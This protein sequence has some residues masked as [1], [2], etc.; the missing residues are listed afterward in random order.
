MEEM[1]GIK[2]A[3]K[4][5]L[6]SD[7]VYI[8]FVTA[9]ITYALEGYKVNAVRYLLKEEEN[10][11]NALKECLD[12]IVARM[13][14]KEVMCEFDF[15]NKKKLIPADSILYVESRLHKVIFFVME[16]V[17]TEYSKYDKLDAVEE[18]LKQYGF[19]RTHQSFLVNMKYAKGVERYKMSLITGTQISISK[20][21]YKSV[22]NEYIKQQGDI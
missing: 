1:D 9:Y 2:T 17:I 6:V 20:K 15:S 22:E 19:C 21:Y 8:V 16:D 7:K 3:E 13:N 11:T 10:L 5:R 12:T 4:I 14:Y 18:S